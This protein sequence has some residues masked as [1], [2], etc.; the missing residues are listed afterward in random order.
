MATV[1]H[2]R[3]RWYGEKIKAK[4]LNHME[5]NMDAAAIFL[6]NVIRELISKGGGTAEAKAERNAR[7]TTENSWSASA[8]EWRKRSGA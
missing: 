4:I 1:K 5:R 7:E 6:T 8:R 2:T 3:V